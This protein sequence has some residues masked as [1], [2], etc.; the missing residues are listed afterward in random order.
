[1]FEPSCP[2]KRPVRPHTKKGRHLISP[3]HRDELAVK[4]I[5]QRISAVVEPEL[6]NGVHGWRKGGSVQTAV[7]HIRLLPGERLSFDIEAYF[8][9]IDQQRMRH[10]LDRL[11]PTLWP[12]IQRWL[13]DIGLP[14]GFAFSPALGNLYLAD[15]DRRFPIVRYCD[16]IMVIDQ[17][18]NRVFGKLE[19]HLADIGLT[20]HE[21]TISPTTFCKQRLRGPKRRPPC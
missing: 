5:A 18:P 9:S 8:P 20:C 17:D 6:A 21:K 10:K 11:D 2:T 19:R 15:I 13:P 1:M 3:I 7:R 4:K 12:S 16:N 14:S